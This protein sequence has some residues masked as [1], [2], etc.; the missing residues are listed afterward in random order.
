VIAIFWAP[1]IQ[2]FDSLVSYYQEVVSYLAPPIVGTFFLGLFWKR[3]NEN[4]AFWG[5]LSGLLVAAIVMVLKYGIKI[6]MNI[7]FLLLAPVIMVFSVA[8]NVIVSLLSHQPDP[9][10]VAENTW[11]QKIWKAETQELIGTKWYK[12]YRVLAGIL[13]AGCFVMYFLFI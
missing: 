11:T 5:L 6:D 13:V 1:F 10:K 9:V 12:N 8:M 7:H 3:S 2:Q 4:G